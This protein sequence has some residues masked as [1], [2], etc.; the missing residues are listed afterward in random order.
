MDAGRVQA[1]AISGYRSLPNGSL[2]LD[3]IDQKLAS[4]EGFTPVLG[5]HADE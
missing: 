1:R 3:L 4:F 5:A 2:A